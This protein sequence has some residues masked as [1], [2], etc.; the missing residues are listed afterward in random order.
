M[1]VNSSKWPE[2]FLSGQGVFSRLFLYV[3]DVL[4]L[5]CWTCKD[6]RTPVERVRMLELVRTVSASPEHSDSVV[7]MQS[8][9]TVTLGDDVSF[10]GCVRL[11]PGPYSNRVC[12]IREHYFKLPK[13]FFGGGIISVYSVELLELLGGSSPNL[14]LP[15]LTRPGSGILLLRPFADGER[16]HG[17]I[18]RGYWNKPTRG[19]RQVER[20]NELITVD[21]A[22]SLFASYSQV[23]ERTSQSEGC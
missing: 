10:L 1:L 12:R 21:E 5:L 4:R 8:L 6:Q 15:D 7:P 23:S 16:E 9:A 19:T 18:N 20:S 2:L 14:A 3:D 17:C 13:R 22:F 11:G